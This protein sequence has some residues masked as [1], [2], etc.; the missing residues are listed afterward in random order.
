MPGDSL[1]CALCV[2][3]WGRV[4]VATLEG[5]LGTSYLLEPHFYSCVPAVLCG[6]PDLSPVMGWRCM[7]RGLDGFGVAQDDVHGPLAP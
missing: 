1:F 7:A 4:H 3:R 6:D 5:S 2:V